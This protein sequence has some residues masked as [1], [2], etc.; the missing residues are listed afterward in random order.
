MLPSALRAWHVHNHA[1]ECEA[2]E[3]LAG[4]DNIAVGQDDLHQDPELPSLWAQVLARIAIVRVVEAVAKDKP[5][6]LKVSYHKGSEHIERSLYSHGI[7]CC[8]DD[9]YE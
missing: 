4:K 2:Y 1:P 7:L 5:P 3:R 9:H 6:N 8:G